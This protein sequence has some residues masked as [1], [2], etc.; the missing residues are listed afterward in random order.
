MEWLL[1]LKVLNPYY[2]NLK[3]QKKI[4]NK[5]ELKNFF[6]KEYESVKK[7]ELKV[8]NN[9]KITTDSKFDNDINDFP[10]SITNNQLDDF[11]KFLEIED[12]ITQKKIVKSIDF[13]KENNPNEINLF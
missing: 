13:K 2:S 10:D 11:I 3:Y 6:E 5:D 9:F 1:I 4:P 8:P 7:K 12:F